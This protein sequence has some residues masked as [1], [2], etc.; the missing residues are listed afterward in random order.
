MC[1]HDAYFADSFEVGRGNVIMWCMACG[2]RSREAASASA[3]LLAGFVMLMIEGVGM[4]HWLQAF[5]PDAGCSGR[6]LLV[7]S[8]ACILYMYL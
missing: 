3:L 6:S 7:L 1:G 2:C 5:K 8:A 4:L